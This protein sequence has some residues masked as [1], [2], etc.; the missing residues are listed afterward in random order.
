MSGDASVASRFFGVGE[1]FV[2]A[3]LLTI[4]CPDAYEHDARRSSVEIR[5]C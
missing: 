2:H 5:L 1:N 4:F 3:V